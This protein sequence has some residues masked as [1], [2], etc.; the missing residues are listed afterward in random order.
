MLAC[1]LTLAGIDVAIV[2]R[3]GTPDVVASRACGLHSRNIEIFDQGGIADRFLSEGQVAQVR[4]AAAKLDISDFPTRYPYGLGRWQNHIER[5]LAG[6][7]DKL[8]SGLV[9]ESQKMTVAAMQM[10]EKK[11]WAQRS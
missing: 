5:I 6:R 7:D 9:D 8:G 10:A 11:V 3:R 4:S 2:E 1:E